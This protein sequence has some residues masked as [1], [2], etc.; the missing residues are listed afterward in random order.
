ME[1]SRIIGYIDVNMHLSAH[2]VGNFVLLSA[3]MSVLLSEDLS[4]A[5]REGV[6]TTLLRY[7]TIQSC[8]DEDPIMIA[9]DQDPWVTREH[10]DCDMREAV[11]ALGYNLIRIPRQH[12]IGMMK[13]AH[14]VRFFKQAP[15]L[16]MLARSQVDGAWAGGPH[17]AS[18]PRS[19]FQGELS[20]G[21]I[22]DLVT[23]IGASKEERYDAL[24]STLAQ[25]VTIL[26]AWDQ[27]RP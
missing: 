22:Q 25:G 16:M 14:V 12:A 4:P 6:Q 21:T 8:R 20:I 15:H 5:L 2:H 23:W 11:Y 10:V 18:L 19:M 13:M 27:V 26:T 3:P 9:V 7:G 17:E 1:D 24:L